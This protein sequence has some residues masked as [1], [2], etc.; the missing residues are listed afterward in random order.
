MK[1]SWSCQYYSFSWHHF[2]WLNLFVLQPACFPSDVLNESS[3]EPVSTF[4]IYWMASLTLVKGLHTVGTSQYA[5]PFSKTSQDIYPVM[6][7]IILIKFFHHKDL[8]GHAVPRSWPQFPY[9]VLC[10]WGRWFQRREITQW[11]E[12]AKDLETAGSAF[13]SCL[14]LYSLCELGL[15][16]LGLLGLNYLN[17]K[18]GMKISTLQ[19]T[20]FPRGI[21]KYENILSLGPR[22]GKCAAISKFSIVTY[23]QWICLLFKSLVLAHFLCTGLQST[24][25]EPKIW[26]PPPPPPPPAFNL[27]CDSP[28]Y[29][30]KSKRGR[31]IPWLHSLKQGSVFVHQTPR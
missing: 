7:A 18:M 14:W 11:C 17:C 26:L 15:L 16:G 1:Q 27:W 8:I 6:Q 13:E 28:S 21:P 25:S 22:V 20:L 19:V 12:R 2:I 30:E 10:I 9:K 3:Q 31:Q 29:R 23:S 5:R 4:T 24:R